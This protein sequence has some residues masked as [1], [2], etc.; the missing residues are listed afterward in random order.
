M[1]KTGYIPPKQRKKILLISDDIR[2]PSGVGIVGRE[3]VI[4]T[5]HHYNWVQV[6]GAL[7][8][9]EEGKK[10]DI[11]QEINKLADIE[12]S[13]VMQYPRNGY[14]DPDLIR[15][16]LDIEKPDA[17]FLITDPRYFDW[18]FQME[19]EIRKKIPI[20]Y[21]QIWDDLPAP[22]Y[23]KAFYESCDAL[24]GISKQTCLINKLVLREKAEDKIMEYVPHGINHKEFY[25]I[26]DPKGKIIFSPEQK[27]EDY[28]NLQSFKSKVFGGKNI[29]F[30][31]LFNSRNIRRK[32]IPDTMLAWKYFIDQ[33]SPEEADKCA[34]VLHTQLVDEAGT[35]LIAIR[36]YIF[37]DDYENLIFS[38][39]R[40]ATKDLNLLYNSCD[41][42]ILLTSNEGWGLSLTEALMVGNPII[43]NVTGGMQ[44]QMRFIDDDNMWFTPTKDIPSN[45]TGRF[46][47]CAPFA[48][49]VFPSSRS[50]QGSP[51]TPYIWDDRCNPEDAAEQIMN[52]YKLE[53]IKL[54]GLEGRRWAQSQ[55]SGFSSKQMSNTIM[56]SV[57]K[58]FK[59]WK[60]R[61]K[62]EIIPANEYVQDRINHKLRY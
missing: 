10:I 54:V 6:A 48:F 28:D 36:D 5:C 45:H 60:P 9:P 26:L 23:N 13:Y 50:L 31:V 7:K 37:G 29:E 27:P 8:H 46:K 1:T 40:L 34:L 55:E 16:L 24:L 3:M 21:L 18:L 42:Q 33:L 39:S 47:K 12:D 52:V 25:P 59:T 62:Y 20:I 2:L 19:N 4:N 38:T 57:D 11:S 58:L 17:I 15:I 22:S 49:P 53:N 56:E 41:A 61:T 35:D 14:G 43:A 51:K 32:Q 30:A 44:D